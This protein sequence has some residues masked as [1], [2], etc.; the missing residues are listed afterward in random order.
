M[1]DVEEN[2]WEGFVSLVKKFLG[3]RESEDYRE[4]V[5]SLMENVYVLGGNMSIKIHFFNSHCEMFTANFGDMGDEQSERFQQDIKVM[6][7][8]YQGH[9]EHSNNGRLLLK[10]SLRL[11]W[12]ATFKTVNETEG[13]A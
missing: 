5:E 6:V 10:Y 13:Y 2:S 11:C 1:T 3:D 9:W 7:D 8:R 12:E 4:L